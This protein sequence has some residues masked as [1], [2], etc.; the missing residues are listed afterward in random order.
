LFA[1]LFGAGVILLTSRIENNYAPADVARIYYRRNMWL[2][3]F[4]LVHAYLLLRGD[5]DILFR[6]GVVALVLYPLRNLAPRH[7]IALGLAGLLVIAAPNAYRAIEKTRMS[8]SYAVAKQALESGADLS[9]EQR[10]LVKTWDRWMER[11]LPREEVIARKIEHH[12][13]NYIEIFAV[14]VPQA[15]N[16]QTRDLY[17]RT[18]ID[19]F[20]LMLFGMALMKLGIL[21]LKRPSG[22]Y[23]LMVAGGYGI[24][25]PINLW[26][27]VTLISGEFDMLSR[28]MV[29]PTYD[30]GRVATA[31]GHIGALLLLCRSGWAPRLQERLAAV[32]RMAL[33]NYIMQ[34]VLGA[35]IFW[36][37]G[38]G[39]YGSLERYQLYY[40]VLAIWVFQLL[41]STY[42]LQNFRYGPIE[43]LWRTLTY[44]ELQPMRRHVPSE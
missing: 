6:Y 19:S 17:Q 20:A 35:L 40:V 16:S 43:W 30:L 34:T 4:G 37:I 27:T 25:L 28:A 33:T 44:R 32:G 15:A 23:W 22:V 3:A 12:S 14:R 5:G 8:N 38:L 24:G 2:I 31:V 18:F 26:E 13:G 36:G 11:G 42:W 21:T 10:K 1:I 41:S 39:L 7:L 29:M 9:D